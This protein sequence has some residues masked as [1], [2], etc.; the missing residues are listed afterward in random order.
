MSAPSNA[1]RAGWGALQRLD[2][3]DLALRLTLITFLLKP[4]GGAWIVPWVLSLTVAALLVPA[5]ARSVWA[6]GGFT[7]LATT[8]ILLDW[9]L[10]DNHAYLLVYW[11]FAISL[12]LASNTLA[13]VLRWNGR[14]LI[15]A[16]FAF[17][18]LWKLG[19]SYDFVDGTFFRV[20]LLTDARFEHFVQLAGGLDAETLE[21][22]RAFV[23]QHTDTRLE[24]APVFPTR[25][26]TLGALLTVFT[27]LA[28]GAVALTF[29][30]PGT[31]G[32]A[33]W[34]DA[35]LLFF[36]TT[37]YAVATVAGFGWLLLTMGL[38]Q[39]DPERPHL[40][41]LYLGAFLMILL[42]REVAWVRILLDAT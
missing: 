15:G 18:V 39:S 14:Y 6:W 20:T 17:A 37:V 2:P 8:R 42:Y 28:E 41:I 26:W 27:L 16:T 33:R 22:L 34:R 35:A 31:H 19:F 32:P 30:W 40:R 1:A 25:F 9:P 24:L 3:L 7:V 29:L 23:L 10:P 12:G 21:T 36:C 4:I 5:L 13:S 38:A 11:C